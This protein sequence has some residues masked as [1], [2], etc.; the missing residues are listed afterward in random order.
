V[1]K[2]ESV[3]P[4]FGREFQ[5]LEELQTDR[6]GLSQKILVQR[7]LPIL[8]PHIPAAGTTRIIAKI[9]HERFLTR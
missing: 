4:Y 8:L 9:E 7:V 5:K 3:S 2:A 6:V 1:I